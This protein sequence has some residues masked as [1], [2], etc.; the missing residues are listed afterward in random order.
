VKADNCIAGK[1]FGLAII[2]LRI[3][4]QASKSNDSEKKGRVGI[5]FSISGPFLAKSKWRSTCFTKS[6][7]IVA[8]LLFFLLISFFQCYFHGLNFPFF[9]PFTFSLGLALLVI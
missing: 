6:W 1:H 7:S 5:T 9:P 3:A 8:K 2:A 4:R